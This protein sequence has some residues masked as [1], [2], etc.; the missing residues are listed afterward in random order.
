LKKKPSTRIQWSIH[1]HR[2]ELNDQ[3][4]KNH[5]SEL[6][7]QYMI[8]NQYSDWWCTVLMYYV[9]II[10][11]DL[12]ILQIINSSWFLS[13]STFVGR[14]CDPNICDRMYAFNDHTSLVLVYLSITIYLLLLA[15]I[16]YWMLF[17]QHSWPCGPNKCL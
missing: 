14:P 16:Y 9:F 2:S 12:F 7:D 13:L 5:Q 17:I 4:M 10:Q 3:Y 6:N 11:F 1:N 8:I 15:I